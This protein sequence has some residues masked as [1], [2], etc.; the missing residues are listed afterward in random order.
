MAFGDNGNDVEMLKNA[1]LAVAVGN[2]QPIA[3][4]SADIIIGSNDEDGVAQ[5]LLGQI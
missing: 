3:K 5:F 1:D 2:A 4:S